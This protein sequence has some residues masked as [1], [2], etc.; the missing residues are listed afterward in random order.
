MAHVF[1]GWMA[2][3]SGKTFLLSLKLFQQVVLVQIA[4]LTLTEYL[5]GQESQTRAVRKSKNLVDIYKFEAFF[6]KTFCFYSCQ[7]L[8]GGQLAPHF[9]RP[10]FSPPSY[11]HSGSVENCFALSTPKLDLIDIGNF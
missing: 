8:C 1:T 7:N 10:C 3:E 6:R 11:G 5:L 9:R 4:K 2:F